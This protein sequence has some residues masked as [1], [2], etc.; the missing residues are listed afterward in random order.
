MKLEVSTRCNGLPRRKGSD[1]CL[2]DQGK[3]SREGGVSV[4]T[5]RLG[6]RREGL[7][8][9]NAKLETTVGARANE[10]ERTSLSGEV[11]R[12]EGGK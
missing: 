5:R 10:L 3:L 12:L 7:P 4:K 2:G 11:T 8:S 1:I 6:K 9:R